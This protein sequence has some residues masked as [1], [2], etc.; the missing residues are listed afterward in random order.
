MALSRQVLRAGA[1][2][3]LGA[4]APS[5]SVAAVSR[6]FQTSAARRGAQASHQQDDDE[7]YPSEGFSAPIWRNTVLFV[8]AATGIYRF[9]N[10][11]AD[12]HPSRASSSGRSAPGN[13]SED[14]EHDDDNRPFLTRYMDYYFT[15][16]SFWKER[17][18][19]HLDYVRERA[20]EKLLFQDA[21]RPPIHRLRYPST[22]EQASPH[23]ISAGDQVDLSD[24]HVKKA[25]E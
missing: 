10:L 12:P 5:L 17:N 18:E 2:R 16:A 3:S 7:T 23:R 15:P 6:S 1:M 11:H 21:E 14:D 24:L 19:R 25:S 20:E 22:F 4:T 8:I 9:S 13:E